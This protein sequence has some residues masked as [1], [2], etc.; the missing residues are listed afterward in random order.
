MDH[1][2]IIGAVTQMRYAPLPYVHADSS[3]CG[4]MLPGNLLFTGQVALQRALDA[5]HVT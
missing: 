5:N 1:G 4:T 2:E 3:M